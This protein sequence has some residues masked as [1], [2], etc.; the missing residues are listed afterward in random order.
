[1]T[2]LTTIV[3]VG[4]SG[5]G[6]SM[7]AQ[8]IVSRLPNVRHVQASQ[9][10]KDALHAQSEE[11]RLGPVRDNQAVL[12]EAFN[13]LRSS[14][15]EV[16]LLDAHCVIDTAEGIVVIPAEVFRSFHPTAFIEVW[17]EP[18]LIVSRRAADSTRVRP[19]RDEDD[20]REHQRM[21]GEKAAQYAAQLRV[22]I[23]RVKSGDEESAI[24]AVSKSMPSA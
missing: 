8:A 16:I 21:S 11:L 13:K 17:E 14:T 9:L 2:Q 24:A 7:L 19:K 22:R 10:L 23:T 5:V 3:M 1:V 20:V 18:G 15:E 12:I 4:V 6:K